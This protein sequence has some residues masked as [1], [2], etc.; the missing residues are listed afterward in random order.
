LWDEDKE[1]YLDS[2]NWGLNIQVGIQCDVSRVVCQNRNVFAHVLHQQ[3]VVDLLQEMAF[4]MRDNQLKQKVAQAAA[5]ALDNQENGQWGEM[6]KLQK[7]IEAA[8]FD[9]SGLSPVCN[10]CNAGRRG[11]KGGSA[12]G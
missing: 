7:A 1:M 2:T 11:I 8:D 6:K 12:W 4:S 5:V 9:F 10:P 3:L